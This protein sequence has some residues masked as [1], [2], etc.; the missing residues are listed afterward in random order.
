MSTPSPQ[1]PNEQQQVVFPEFLALIVLL[2]LFLFVGL[3][4]L[5]AIVMGGGEHDQDVAGRQAYRPADF[6]ETIDWDASLHPEQSEWLSA[7]DERLFSVPPAPLSEDIYPCTACHDPEDPEYD[8]EPR[9][10]GMHDEIALQHGSADRW[11]FDCHNP[12]DRDK[13]RLANGTLIGFDESY[14]LCGQCHGT[15]YRDWRQ[16]I[17]GRRVGYWDGRKA[18]LLCA[19]C[20]N[21]HAPRFQAMEPLPPPVRP[22]HLRESMEESG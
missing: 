15:I 8:P 14:K 4:A 1:G 21:P 5:F 12:E 20:H 9:E 6:A 19:H 18:Y 3:I 10:L 7:G 17:H 16:G 22:D 13:L 11:C 2:G